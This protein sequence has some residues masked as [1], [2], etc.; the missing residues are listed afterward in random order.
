MANVGLV[1]S[2]SKE[3]PGVLVLTIDRPPV[4]AMSLDLFR[5]LRDTMRTVADDPAIRCVILTGAGKVFCAGADVKELSER[6]TESQF[7]RSEI[8]R[9]CF[10]AIRSCP[11]PVIAAVNGAALGAGL[12]MASCCDLLISSERAVFSLPEINVGVMG[13]PRHAARVLPD[14]LVRYLA[15]T[16]RKIDGETLMRYGGANEVVP[17]E[18]LLPSAFAIADEIARKGPKTIRLMKESINLTEDMPI[19]EGYRVEQLFT[20]LASSME[21][22]KEAS[23]AFV[24]KRDPHWVAD[25]KK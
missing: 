12:V 4:N 25:L 2:T 11:L 14:K 7:A 8:S 15:L 18:D 21:E 3:H 17:H 6:T 9:A 5:H 23:R 10:D 13:G 24:E 22:S 16:G 19:T 20:T 1:A